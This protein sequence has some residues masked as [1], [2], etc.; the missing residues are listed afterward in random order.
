MSAWVVL[1]VVVSVVGVVVG[2][3]GYNGPLI[4]FKNQHNVPVSVY[5]DSF[6]EGNEKNGLIPL[7]H[8]LPGDRRY[9]RTS[10]GHSFEAYESYTRVFLNLVPVQDFEQ[11]VFILGPVQQCGKDDDNINDSLSLIQPTTPLSVL[12]DWQIFMKNALPLY[13]EKRI[14]HPSKEH[15]QARA[16]EE[17][18]RQYLNKEQPKITPTFT[19]I[20]YE[21]R[22]LDP[23]LFSELKTF[24]EENRHK[25]QVEHLGMTNHHMNHWE[26]PTYIISLPAQLRNKVIATVK[27]VL[28]DWI[29]GGYNLEYTSLYGIR[30]YVNNSY[31][32][33]HVDRSAT[34]AVSAIIQIDQR[35]NED[36]LL[37]VIGHDKKVRHVKLLPGQMAL[38]ESAS[39]IHG[40]EK[41]LNGDYFSNLFVHYRPRD[42]WNVASL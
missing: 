29:G 31:L 38:Y 8:I 19:K 3:G 28:E 20:G 40:R 23:Q 21:V 1:L 13:R 6:D 18:R 36:W 39:V 11:T 22:Q 32:L 35:V 41:R 24:W 15:S 27:P 12:A 33:N 10:I 5:W 14:I 9:I 26:V 4:E 2:E 30:M 17:K 25:I 7:E 34:H 37:E 42:N 16:R